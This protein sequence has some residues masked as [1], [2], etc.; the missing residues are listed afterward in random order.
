MT[1]TA[2]Y[3]VNWNAVLIEPFSE[4]HGWDASAYRGFSFWIAA[5]T[6]AKSRMRIAARARPGAFA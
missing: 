6:N 2:S 1:P 5:G 4:A 3:P